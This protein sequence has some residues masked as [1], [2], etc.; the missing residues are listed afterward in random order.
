MCY[1]IKGIAPIIFLVILGFL[2]CVSTAYDKALERTSSFTN[3]EENVYRIAPQVVSQL[4][5]SM[6]GFTGTLSLHGF[7]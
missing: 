3:T 2:R 6:A 5:Y 7:L 1:P 4:L